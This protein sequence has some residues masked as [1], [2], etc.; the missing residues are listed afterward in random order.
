M[1]TEPSATRPVDIRRGQDMQGNRSLKHSSTRGRQMGYFS[2]QT[3]IADPFKR[4]LPST[5]F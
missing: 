2:P 5:E 1:V 4:V 3:T